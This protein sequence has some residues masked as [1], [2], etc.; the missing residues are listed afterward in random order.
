MILLTEIITNSVTEKMC[1]INYKSWDD[2]APPHMKKAHRRRVSSFELESATFLA[3]LL[4]SNAG[5]NQ[6]L[7]ARSSMACILT[8][9][10]KT[11]EKPVL[12]H[13]ASRDELLF[14]QLFGILYRGRVQQQLPMGTTLT[15]LLY[16]ICYF[17]Y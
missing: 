11:E 17:F 13:I 8:T 15:K 5:L 12:S 10:R 6:S 16:V 9:L 3:V 1:A 14:S 4:L 2:H 7:I